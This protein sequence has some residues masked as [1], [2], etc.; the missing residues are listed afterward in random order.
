MAARTG[1]GVAI[2]GI[3]V[4]DMVFRADRQP[5]IGET[6]LGRSFALGPGGKGSNQAVACARAGAETTF[7]TRLG[8]D[9]FGAMATEIWTDAGV[10]PDVIRG[11]GS[12]TGAAYI[13]VE[14]TSGSNAIIVTPGAAAEITPEDVTRWAP[15]ITGASV[16]VTQLEQ[17]IPAAAHALRLAHEAGVTTILN[18]APA[19]ELDPGIWPLCTY[20]TPNET[21]TE[22]L[23][24]LPVRSI[25]E[26][27]TAAQKLCTMGVGTA[28]ITLGE[29]GVLVHG[30]D[31]S[32][33]VPAVT[34]GD[35]VDTTG[36]GD[37]FNG[38]FAA[39]L[40]A[41]RDREAAAR[42]GVA[43]AGLSVTGHGTAASMPTAPE[44][45]AVLART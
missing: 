21:E 41:G 38:G 32:V 9:T 37:A 12:Y 28:I 42:F 34:C 43:T 10:T 18:P 23:T 19:A 24:G 44:I 1:S 27:R 39:A 36:A 4:A 33:H 45:E 8:D 30:P 2:L 3:F 25:D 5:Q 29:A 17:P 20:A 6:L 35:V 26:A 16:F 7:L 13:F 11:A 14:D 15:A 40:A 31:I 22:Q